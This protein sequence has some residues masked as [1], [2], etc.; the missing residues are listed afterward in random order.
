MDFFPAIMM[1][2]KKMRNSL[3]SETSLNKEKLI[4]K[5]INR[6]IIKEQIQKI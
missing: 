4:Q 6:K 2:T 3:K 1:Q 5:L